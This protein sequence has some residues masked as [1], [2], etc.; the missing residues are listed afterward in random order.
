MRILGLTGG[1]ATGKSTVAKMLLDFGVPVHDADA[2]V[3]ELYR[4]NHDL[5]KQISALFSGSVTKGILDRKK[6][7]SYV[8]KDMA[9]LK[10]LEAIVHPKVDESQQQFLD[11]HR[12]QC[13]PL[14]V[15]DIPLLFEGGYEK[16]CD[17]ILVLTCSKEEQKRR[18]LKRPG[19]TLTHFEQLS[20]RLM[21]S[22]KKSRRA[23]FVINTE[24]PLESTLLKLKTVL[25]NCNVAV[26]ENINA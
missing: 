4:T 2:C 13:T 18:I 12:A 5:I 11:S 9:N 7:N 19:M 8:L 14:V 20:N 24:G 26:N 23:D 1:I 15:L 17:N 22:E 21:D 10:R 3:H 25:K 16:L 6:L